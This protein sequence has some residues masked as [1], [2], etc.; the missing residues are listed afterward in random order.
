MLYLVTLR[1]RIWWRGD[2]KIGADEAGA[3]KAGADEAGADEAG[4]N[5]AGANVG[6]RFGRASTA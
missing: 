4:A 6:W 1:R 3:D 5:K 2:V